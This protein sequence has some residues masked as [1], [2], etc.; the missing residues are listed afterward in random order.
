MF[1]LINQIPLNRFWTPPDRYP[2]NQS[3][4]G[5]DIGGATTRQSHK[6]NSKVEIF[7]E[8]K[9]PNKKKHVKEV[10]QGNSKDFLWQRNPRICKSMLWCLINSCFLKEYICNFLRIKGSYIFMIKK[11]IFFG[12]HSQFIHPSSQFDWGKFTKLCKNEVEIFHKNYD[13]FKRKK[14]TG[15]LE[16]S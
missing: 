15:S 7:E 12:Q 10:F 8:K 4:E 14:M 13:A 3:K 6:F 1:W 2:T 16:N 9:V 5:C 11:I